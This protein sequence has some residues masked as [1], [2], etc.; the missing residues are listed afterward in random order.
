MQDLLKVLEVLTPKDCC[1]KDLCSCI[2]NLSPDMFVFLVRF[3]HTRNNQSATS[4]DLREKFHLC[5]EFESISYLNELQDATPN[6]IFCSSELQLK[7]LII[8]FQ[9]P[10]STVCTSLQRCYF[11]Q[12]ILKQ[13]HILGLYTVLKMFCNAR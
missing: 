8:R 13:Q 5:I 2:Y 7:L 10:H 4:K 12:Q 1:H 11:L 9:H 6:Q 3:F